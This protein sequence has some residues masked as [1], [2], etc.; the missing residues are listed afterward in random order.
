MNLYSFEQFLKQTRINNFLYIRNIKNILKNSGC[1][2]ILTFLLQKI[3]VL[4]ISEF[5]E[6]AFEIF[7]IKISYLTEKSPGLRIGISK[8]FSQGVKNLGPMR[9]YA[10]FI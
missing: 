10:Y 4:N 8:I 7:Q 9:V 2:R 5:Q 3:P 1:F 6:I